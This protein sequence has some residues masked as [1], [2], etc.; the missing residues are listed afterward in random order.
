[1]AFETHIIALNWVRG[2]Y[3]VASSIIGHIDLDKLYKEK[4]LF[5]VTNE[6]TYVDEACV[7]SRRE[8]PNYLREENFTGAERVRL[9]FES[10][11]RDVQFL[12]VH[13]AEWESGMN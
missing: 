7:L 8:F 2:E 6:M 1:M 3:S 5:D 13:V 12:V 11:S 4:R 10:L 9:W